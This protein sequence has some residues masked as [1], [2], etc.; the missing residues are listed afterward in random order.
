M[1]GSSLFLFEPQFN[2]TWVRNLCFTTLT[3]TR[4]QAQTMSFESKSDVHHHPL[5]FKAW[6]FSKVSSY[7]KKLYHYTYVTLLPVTSWHFF[8]IN[9]FICTKLLTRASMPPLLLLENCSLGTFSNLPK[10]TKLE[11]GTE[12][13]DF[14]PAQCQ[15]HE[16]ALSFQMQ[17]FHFG[18]HFGIHDFALCYFFTVN[19][20]YKKSYQKA[21]ASNLG[22]Q[23]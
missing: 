15:W 13:F 17:T 10:D 21:V 7:L 22:H 3:S 20:A 9:T 2:I 12:H 14:N 19:T 23:Q 18:R 8:V 5:E 4:R 6:I 1:T 16:P 11:A